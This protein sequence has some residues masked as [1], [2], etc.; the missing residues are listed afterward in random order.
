MSNPPT[1]TAKKGN[2]LKR[3]VQY[4]W[5]CLSPYLLQRL[6]RPAMKGRVHLIL[7]VADH[8]EPSSIPGDYAGYAPRDVQ[9]KRLETWCNQYPKNFER[10]RD[11]DGFHLTHTHFYPA[12]QYDRGLVERLS[13]FCHAGWGEVEIHLHHGVSEVATAETTRNQIVSFRDTLAR[14]HGCLS[15]EEGDSTPKYV[16]VHGNFA[17]AN[18]A[19]GFGC[20]VDSEMQLLAETGCYADMTYPTSAFH[21]AQISKLNS[22][23]ECTLP[24][25]KRAPQRRGRELK[26]GR[27]VSTL[28]IIVQGPWM[29]DFDR[30]SRTGLGRIENGS[31]TGCN[32]PSVRRLQLW[33][34]AGIAVAGRP[35]WIF[36]KLDTHGMDPRDTDTVLG[37]RM[38]RFLGELL[39][40]ASERQEI[41]HFVSAREMTNILFAACDGKEGNPGEYRDY[42]YKMARTQPRVSPTTAPAMVTRG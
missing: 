28:P 21:P 31:L 5:K 17:L 40:G 19:G 13:E 27:P 11:S 10:F 15:Y 38:Q 3:R 23:Y 41:L 22:L 39:G 35:D 8:F 42:R 12:E 16:F 18:S 29:L 34:K 25:E 14:E 20:G 2:K 1:V 33:K 32:P 26:A 7:A 9:E 36:V 30:T 6:T 4:A 24:L 37:D